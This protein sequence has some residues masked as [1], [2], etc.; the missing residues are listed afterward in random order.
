RWGA[1]KAPGLGARAHAD[2]RA[3]R[4]GVERGRPAGKPLHSAPAP[5]IASVADPG[6]RSGRVLPDRGAFV[7]GGEPAG[8]NGPS[9]RTRPRR[10]PRGLASCGS[11]RDDPLRDQRTAIGLPGDPVAPLSGTGTKT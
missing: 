10:W 5:S 3:P 11:E 4:D 7:D 2:R 8:A 1:S 9:E 6:R